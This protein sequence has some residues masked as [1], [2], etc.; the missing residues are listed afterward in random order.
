MKT[1]ERQSAIMKALKNAVS[2]LTGRYLAEFY[3]VSRQV[4]VQDIAVL[5]ASGVS[6]VASSQGYFLLGEDKKSVK[7]QTVACVHKKSDIEEELRLM[8]EYGCVVRDVI[9][10]HPVYGELVATL[11]IRNHEDLERFLCALNG[12]DAN[13]LSKLTGG[14]HIHT[15]EVPSERAFQ[16]LVRDLNKK[17]FLYKEE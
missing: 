10:D 13:P 16:A 8:L 1:K 11:M 3:G 17:G 12:K 9:V 7:I 2:P 5:R 6:I 15:L 4:I 14:V